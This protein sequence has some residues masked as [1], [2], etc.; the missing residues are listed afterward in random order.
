MG[1]GAA[2]L[3]SKR[4]DSMGDNPNGTTHGSNTRTS[5]GCLHRRQRATGCVYRYAPTNADSHGK[6]QR[7]DRSRRPPYGSADCIPATS[8]PRIQGRIHTCHASLPSIR[9]R[10][11]R[12]GSSP[13]SSIYL[14]LTRETRQPRY[15]CGHQT[16]R[17]REWPKGMRLTPSPRPQR[18]A[19]LWTLIF[20][21]RADPPAEDAAE[22]SENRSRSGFQHPWARRVRRC[23]VLVAA[24]EGSGS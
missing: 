8:H 11:R 12:T 1:T 18:E 14:A 9:E 7:R 15:P 22:H 13:F 10:P 20:R 6:R 16:R 23:S 19:T 5:S 3:T 21:P 4:H 2:G 24:A 17:M